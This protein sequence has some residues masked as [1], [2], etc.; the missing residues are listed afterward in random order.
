MAAELD[1]A[2]AIHLAAAVPALAIGAVQYLRRPR[3]DGAHRVLGVL[4]AAAMYIAAISSFWIRL[5]N[6]PA[7]SWIH[8]LSVLILVSVTMALW[9]AHRGNAEAHRGWAV[10]AYLGLLGAFA[11]ALTPGRL[12]PDL[13]FGGG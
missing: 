12:L 6:S 13:L 3:G 2:I 5:L 4:W 1:P 9:H 11:G 10:G 8:A 7:P